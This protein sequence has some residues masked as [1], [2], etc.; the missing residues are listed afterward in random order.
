[1][2]RRGEGYGG[3]QNHLNACVP[4][5]NLHQRLN[6]HFLN[7]GPSHP[8]LPLLTIRRAADQGLFRATLDGMS[9]TL[10]ARTAVYDVGCAAASF[11]S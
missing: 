7:P 11:S 8:I 5:V 3:R 6:H 10:P 2:A 1:M 9:I 4:N